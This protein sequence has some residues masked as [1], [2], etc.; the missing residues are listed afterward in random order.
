MSNFNELLTTQRNT[1]LDNI[2]NAANA[3]R[4]I[5]LFGAG[6]VGQF[7]AQ[8][9]LNKKIKISAFC[10][11]NP[12]KHGTQI[13]NIP[14]ISYDTL[15]EKFKDALVIITLGPQKYCD[16]VI[17]QLKSDNIFSDFIKSDGFYLFSKT[18]IDTIVNNQIN[19]FK[20]IYEKLEDRR[21][22]HVFINKLNYMISGDRKYLQGIQ[23][24]DQYFCKDFIKLSY[25]DIFIDCG[26]Y[27]GKNSIDFIKLTGNDEAHAIIFEPDYSNIKL[28]EENTKTYKNITIIPSATWSHDCD[29]KISMTSGQGSAISDFGETVIHARSIDSVLNGEKASFIKMDVEGAEY[30]S[31]LGAE[32]T[33]RNYRPLLA[34]CLYHSFEDHWRLPELIFSMCPNYTFYIRNHYDS[35]VET[36]F[37][38]I[39]QK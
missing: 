33:I 7:A 20:N 19:S 25:N 10:D 3:G 9:L 24:P 29:L 4:P 35:E 37:Y 31:L 23:D 6:G 16:Q 13:L 28:L 14:V 27:D 5:I 22:Q 21:S 32:K 18:E 26:G 8:K 36:V 30:E 34:V 2:N 1:I 38:A 12:E 39:P 11:N 17:R 15:K